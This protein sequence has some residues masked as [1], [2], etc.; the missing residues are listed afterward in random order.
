ML[1]PEGLP[2]HTGGEDIGVVAARDGRE[3]IRIVDACLGQGV[4]V[5]TDTRHHPPVERGA[6]P[7]EGTGV[8]IDDRNVMSQS[9]HSA[10]QRGTHP[11][12]SHDHEVHG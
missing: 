3:G 1:D 12:A 6:E 8:L 5:K 2:G 9:V 7:V 4:S 10:C 11:A